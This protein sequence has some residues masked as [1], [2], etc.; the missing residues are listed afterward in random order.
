MTQPVAE[1]TVSSPLI[2]NAFAQALEMALHGD[3]KQGAWYNGLVFALEGASAERASAHA[4]GRS[5]VLQHAEHARY[6]LQMVNRWLRGEQPEAD[7]SAAWK[8]ETLNDLEWEA[9]KADLKTQLEMLLEVART[10][11]AWRERGLAMMIHNV[12]HAAYHAGAIRQLL[13][14]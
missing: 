13:K 5:S 11:P 7:W 12:A 9:L 3:E 4:P 14:D 10:R 6:C 2:A 1:E 8:L